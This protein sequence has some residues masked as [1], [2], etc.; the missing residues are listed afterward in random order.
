[1]FLTNNHLFI[2]FNTDTFLLQLTYGYKVHCYKAFRRNPQMGVSIS[3]YKNESDALIRHI[4]ISSTKNKSWSW[5][6]HMGQPFVWWDCSKSANCIFTLFIWVLVTARHFSTTFVSFIT[7]LMFRSYL[8]SARQKPLILWWSFTEENEDIDQ[9]LADMDAQEVARLQELNELEK[10]MVR[11]F[12]FHSRSKFSWN[13][14]DMALY[15]I[16]SW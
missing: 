12:L 16:A 4:G 6:K 11:I 13:T 10:E 8:C 9:E 3:N 2:K 15:C 1:M 7:A 14:L 5:G